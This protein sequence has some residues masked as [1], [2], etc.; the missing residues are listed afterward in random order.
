MRVTFSATISAELTKYGINVA[1]DT[2]GQN[3]QLCSKFQK[4]ILT[5]LL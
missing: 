3:T 2:S 4:E 5:D 1:N